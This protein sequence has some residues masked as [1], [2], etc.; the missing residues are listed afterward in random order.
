MNALP[1]FPNSVIH[2]VRRAF[3]AANRRV[4]AKILSTPNCPEP[5]L[6]MT[7]VE[8]LSHYS[9]ARVVAPG[10]IVRLDVHYLGGLRHFYGWEIADIGI[11]VFAKSAGTVRANKVA[12]LQSK[13]LYPLRH[14]ILEETEADYQIGMGRLLPGAPTLPSLSSPYLFEFTPK[15]R[16]QALAV[17]DEQYRAIAEYEAKRHLPVHYLLYNSWSVPV[18]YA[19]PIVGNSTLSRASNGGA[20]V[21][22]ATAIRRALKNSPS[23]Y[24]PSFDDVSTLVSSARAHKNGWRL[25]HF[26]SRLVLGCR[27]G[28]LFED[29]SDENV[30]ALFNRR[31]GPISA[32]VSVTIEQFD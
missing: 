27:E 22:P 23:G 20:R 4:G 14:G 31:S 25:E 24:C 1:K 5:S 12:L 13:R 28:A 2:Y 3:A 30:F 11:M 8:A 17:D 16:Y 29:L 32:A 19:L 15:S 18:S 6:D 26:V 21:I 9:G 10:W 7:L